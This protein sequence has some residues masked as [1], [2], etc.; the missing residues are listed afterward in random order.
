MSDYSLVEVTW[1]DA[2]SHPNDS[3]LDRE[4]ISETIG[5]DPYEVRSVGYLIA[6]CKPNYVVLAQT[7]CDEQ[8]DSVLCIPVGMV[9]R[10]RVIS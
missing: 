9:Q 1:Y 6:D 4:G 10:V 5:D 8:V 2:Y 7:M 3:W